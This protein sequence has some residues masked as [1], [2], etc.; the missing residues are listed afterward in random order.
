M[1]QHL[2]DRFAGD[3]GGI[4][5]ALPHAHRATRSYVPAPLLNP[6]RERPEAGSWT[7]YRHRWS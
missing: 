2:P 1:K 5:R 3:F 6:G 7:G 4:T